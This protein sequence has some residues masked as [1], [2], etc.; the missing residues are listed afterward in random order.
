M[1]RK[2]FL[3]VVSSSWVGW[4]LSQSL[5]SFSSHRND[6]H[7]AGIKPQ[8]RWAQSRHEATGTVDWFS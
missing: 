6:G 8:E 3:V 1:Y 7:K 4:L 5:S 2:F